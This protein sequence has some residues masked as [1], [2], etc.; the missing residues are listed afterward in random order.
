MA[1][2]EVD[3]V[4]PCGQGLERRREVPQHSGVPHRKQDSH[5]LLV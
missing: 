3:L 4:I 2:D 1:E 5:R